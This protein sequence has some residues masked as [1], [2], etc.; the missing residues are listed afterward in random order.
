MVCRVGAKVD[1][2]KGCK[3]LNQNC[4]ANTQEVRMCWAVSSSWSQRGQ[5]AGCT[6]PIFWRRSAV[7]QRLRIACHMKILNLLGD[8]AL[9]YNPYRR[10]FFI[11]SSLF[12]LGYSIRY[13]KLLG[14]S[15]NFLFRWNGHLYSRGMGLKSGLWGCTSIPPTTSL[16]FKI[17]FPLEC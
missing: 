5:C 6:S 3:M 13:G 17:I 7:Q 16:F 14:G 4:Q 8:Q 2:F 9:V 12:Q 1:R 10:H 11:K 15:G